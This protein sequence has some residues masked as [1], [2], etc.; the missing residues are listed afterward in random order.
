[1]PRCA[2]SMRHG[3]DDVV[4]A[5]PDPQRRVALGIVRRIGPLPGIAYVRLEGDRDHETAAIVVDAA[6]TVGTGLALEAAAALDG[7]FA[8]NLVTVVEVVHGVKDLVRIGK[9]DH[10]AIGE[11]TVHRVHEDGPF[12]LAPEIVRHEESAPE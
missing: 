8:G 12:V 1:M 2:T 3:T 7:T 9:V 10:V 5:D 4:D 11:D 6:P